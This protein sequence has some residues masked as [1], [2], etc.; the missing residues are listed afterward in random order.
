VVVIA[1]KVEKVGDEL[2]L[3]VPD[4]VMESLELKLGDTLYLQD[5]SRGFKLLRDPNAGNADPS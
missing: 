3:I 5:T 2:M 4:D 1:L